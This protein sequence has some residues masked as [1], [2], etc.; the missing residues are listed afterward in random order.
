MHPD[1]ASLRKVL[2]ACLV[3]A[4]VLP[5]VYL[6]CVA[7][8]DLHTRRAEAT[9]VAVRMVRV[10]DE[11]ASKVLDLDATLEAR[12][13]ELV[14][15][16]TSDKIRKNEELHNRFQELGAGYPQVEHIAILDDDGEVL[17]DSRSFPAHPRNVSGRVF[18]DSLRYAGSVMTVSE[19]FHPEASDEPLFLTSTARRDLNGRF[20]GAVSVALRSNYFVRFYQ[21]LVGDGGPVALA[22]LRDD[23]LILARWSPGNNVDPLNQ[24]H[25]ALTPLLKELPEAGVRQLFSV[26]EGEDKIFAYRRVQGYPVIV[27]AAYPVSAIYAQWFHHLVVTAFLFLGPC[28][29][30][31][32]VLALGLRHLKLEEQTWLAM[33]AEAERHR[34]LEAARKESLRLQALGNLV[35]SVAHDFNNLLMTLSANIEIGKRANVAGFDT[36]LRNMERAIR[37]GSAL[38]RRLLGVARKQ[39]LRK[40][41]VSLQ[42]LGEDF[43]LVR[44]SLPERVSLVLDVPDSV[45]PVEVDPADFELAIINVA[46]NAKDALP[47]YGT[48]SITARNVTL[49]HTSAL[50]VRGDFVQLTLADNGVGMPRE[51]FQRAFEP[52]FTTKPM[53]EGTGLGLAHVRAFCEQSGGTVTLETEQGKGT[54]VVLYLPRSVRKAQVKPGRTT[55]TSAAVRLDILL[56][57]DN[58]DVAEAEQAVLALMGHEVHRAANA[59]DALECLKAGRTFDCVISDIQMPGAMNGIDLARTIRCEYP[60]LPVVLITGY[61]EELDR[62]RQMGFPVLSKPFSIDV[63]GKILAKCSRTAEAVS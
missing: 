11:Q 54:A 6:V 46:V 14:Q 21:D 25:S 51:V 9:D 37:R 38:T 41:V 52:L 42:A 30:L 60:N 61:A 12:I 43:G 1:F 44:A 17:A 35:G 15:S 40:E 49:D 28:L 24:V 19:P 57:E 4:L 8:F 33:S 32:L 55:R 53:G 47:G 23:G 36:Q 39:P 31:A 56:V 26:I 29:M 45:W 50:P 22:L 34:A 18:Y 59:S 16:S 62:A 2:R 27:I 5:V 48:F 20:T 3:A 7:V 13:A 63:L 58:N 10:A